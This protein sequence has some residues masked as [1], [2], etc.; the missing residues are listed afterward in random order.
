M[1]N[2][3][4][5]QDVLHS[6]FNTRIVEAQLKERLVKFR[7]TKSRLLIEVQKVK[8]AWE[9]TN[10]D[11]SLRPREVLVDW[12]SSVKPFTVFVS[13][14]SCLVI[15]Y[16]GKPIAAID[17]PE[18]VMKHNPIFG[19]GRRMTSAIKPVIEEFDAL[20]EE[21]LRGVKK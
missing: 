20:T 16:K 4:V 11:K 21:L 2:R 9:A 3:L 10:P 5:D 12:F 15:H 17:V 1:D 6:G 19:V 13:L 8:I 18:R 14:A 7:P